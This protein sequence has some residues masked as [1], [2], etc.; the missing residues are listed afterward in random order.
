MDVYF[1]HSGSGDISK[2]L[3]SLMELNSASCTMFKTP[4][5][6]SHPHNEPSL[7]LSSL[8]PFI[9]SCGICCEMNSLVFILTYF[10]LKANF[11][12]ATHGITQLMYSLLYCISLK[13]FMVYKQ[14]SR[15]F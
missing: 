9:T 13:L 15:S 14:T 4:L 8:L 7:Y 2:D 1:L 11:W 10:V 3:R 5:S 6:V 12:P